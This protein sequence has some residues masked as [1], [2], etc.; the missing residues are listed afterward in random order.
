MSPL[1]FTFL[2]ALVPTYNNAQITTT[3][4]CTAGG[5]T[6]TCAVGTYC[7]VVY[8]YNTNALIGSSA[9]Y[10]SPSPSPTCMPLKAPGSAC[11][12][13]SQCGAT[14]YNPPVSTG[15]VTAYTTPCLNNRCCKSASCT[16]SC[17]ASGNCLGDTSCVSTSTSSTG[18]SST[19]QVN[20][21]Y[22]NYF[23]AYGFSYSGVPAANGNYQSND[24]FL[25]ML[26]FYS[27][28][29]LSLAF[30]APLGHPPSTLALPPLPTA[31]A[32]PTRTWI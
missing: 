18:V 1:L 14:F 11:T 29:G 10:Y 23:S 13:S 25:C 24:A 28:T 31:F 15:V 5:S 4:P 27:A 6:Q 8:P 2:L 26:G 21:C 16:T 7:N 22:V 32:L 9:A 30:P 20:T 19:E 3:V 17:D 12:S